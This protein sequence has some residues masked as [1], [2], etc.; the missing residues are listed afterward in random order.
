[1]KFI[2]N[3]LFAFIAVSL[4]V[5]CKNQPEGEAAKTGEALETD[6]KPSED[7]Q[8]FEMTGGKLYWAA[9]KV[10]G[11]HNGAFNVSKGTVP[12]QPPQINSLQHLSTG[13][14]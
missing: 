2:S 7:A 3:L 8:I 12:E 9:T 1:M 10:G 4:I 5:S 6:E 13:S 11:A 14:K